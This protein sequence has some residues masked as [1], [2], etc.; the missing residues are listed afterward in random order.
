[1]SPANVP[2]TTNLETDLVRKNYTDEE[3]TLLYELGRLS[4]ESGNHRRA[5]ALAR[6]LIAVAPDFIPSYILLATV[7]AFAKAY[8]QATDLIQSVLRLNENNLEAHLLGASI[9]LTQG[10]FTMAGT[11]LGEASERIKFGND[12]PP[13]LANFY[14]I[15]LARFEAK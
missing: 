1:M 5:E 6:G 8:D 9:Y 11:M 13:L 2:S 4:F 7:L 12:I 10:N 3:I 14:Q 15:Q